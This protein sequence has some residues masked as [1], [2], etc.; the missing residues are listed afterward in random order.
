M[1]TIRAAP[2][3]SNSRRHRSLALYLLAARKITDLYCGLRYAIR[4]CRLRE[5]SNA[6]KSLRSVLDDPG[7]QR[8]LDR[9]FRER[10]MRIQDARRYVPTRHI[11]RMVLS[12]VADPDKVIW[13]RTDDLTAKTVF[14][15]DLYFND[16]LPGNWDLH[17][18]NL[19]VTNKHRSVVQHFRDGVPW[20][21]TDIFVNRYRPELARGNSPRGAGS[22]EELLRVY[23]TN[24]EDLYESIRRQGFVVA[25]NRNGKPDIPHV[26][27]ARDGRLLFGDDGNHRLA[28][29]KLL[30]VTRVPCLV[31]ARH[32]EW[33]RIRALVGAAWRRQVLAARRS[34]ARDPS[35]PGRPAREM[36]GPRPVS[37][38]P[39]RSPPGGAP[40]RTRSG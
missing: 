24:V 35:G 32:M 6:A 27:I 16:V 39:L 20:E 19:D 3:S 25:I 29:A 4:F 11:T 8:P 21:S 23:E 22:F 38:R 28:M 30:N 33:Q 37:G 31:R 18:G 34:G 5:W 2:A 40:A 17:L 12:G 13:V 1:G 26:H 7:P 10:F 36:S 15:W 14:P 9:Y